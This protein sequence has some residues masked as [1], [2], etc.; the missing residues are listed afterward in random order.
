MGYEVSVG[1]DGKSLWRPILEE[2]QCPGQNCERA[3]KVSPRD[4]VPGRRL[5]CHSC[6]GRFQIGLA[7]FA[8]GAPTPVA[9]PAP[10]DEGT[11]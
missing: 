11:Q 3:F 6:G 10:Q 9:R 1:T 7:L 5:E 2:V 4:L 8:D